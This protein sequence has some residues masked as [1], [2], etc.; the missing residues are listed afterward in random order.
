MNQEE[1]RENRYFSRLYANKNRL[2]RRVLRMER[3]VARSIASN[4]KSHS[5]QLPFTQNL[6]SDLEWLLTWKL[7]TG[8]VPQVMWCDGVEKLMVKP[9]GKYRIRFKARAWIGPEN[10]DDYPNESDIFGEIE[11]KHT[12]KQLKNYWIAIEYKSTRLVASKT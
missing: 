9:I 2:K 4:L 7:K 6:S 10:S 5:L 3:F 1:F 8:C 12:G 11:I